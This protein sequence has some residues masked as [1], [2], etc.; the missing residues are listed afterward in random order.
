MYL[1][2]RTTLCWIIIIFAWVISF[3]IGF[4]L[5]KIRISNELGSVLL[6]AFIGGGFSLWG[7]LQAT[8]KAAEENRKLTVEREDQHNIIHDIEC[9]FLIIKCLDKFVALRL[10]DPDMTYPDSVLK[11]VYDIENEILDN[12]I[13]LRSCS[14]NT[15]SENFLLPIKEMREVL[16]DI[17]IVEG[18]TL[19]YDL[20]ANGCLSDISLNI[21][22]V[23]IEIVKKIN[24]LRYQVFS[25]LTPTDDEM[26]WEYLGYPIWMQG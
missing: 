11:P 20:R 7:S 10:E 14:L 1:G 23:H 5:Y 21:N 18:N 26:L 16:S 8:K 12:M 22:D 4:N 19:M 25:K 6:G 2:K 9:L 15:I 13:M 24:E 17:V 3:S